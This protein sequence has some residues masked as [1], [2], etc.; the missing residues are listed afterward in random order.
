MNQEVL[1]YHNTEHSFGALAPL[2]GQQE[3][4]KNTNNGC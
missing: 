2:G 4:R 3:E 1:K